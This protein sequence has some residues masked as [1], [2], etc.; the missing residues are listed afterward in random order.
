MVIYVSIFF[1]GY[2]NKDEPLLYG[3][4]SHQNTGDQFDSGSYWNG[5]RREEEVPGRGGYWNGGEEETRW[6]A[7]AEEI[8]MT[9]GEGFNQLYISPYQK[10]D[11]DDGNCN[12]GEFSWIEKKI[13]FLKV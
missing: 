8:D 2:Q 9:Q 10:E 5:G 11:V 6:W 1:K 13:P 4:Y 7:D 3:K 12:E